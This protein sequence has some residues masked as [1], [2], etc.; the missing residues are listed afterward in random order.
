[1][2]FNGVFIGVFTTSVFKI[3]A[4]DYIPDGILTLAG[5]LASACSGFARFFWAYM[6]D[7]FGFRKV[8]TVMTIIQTINSAFIY[9]NRMN[10]YVYPIFVCISSV[11]FGGMYSIFPTATIKIYGIKNGPKINSFVAFSGAS[12]AFL[13]FILNL[14]LS[15]ISEKA[16]F[17]FG[18]ILSGLNFLLVFFFDEDPVVV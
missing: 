17:T 18:T 11:T 15:I 12:A 7:K 14:N 2:L 16:I 9:E 10:Q 1:M 6:L 8:F 3:I 4:I 5:A 13:G